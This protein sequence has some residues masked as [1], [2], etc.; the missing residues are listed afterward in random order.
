MDLPSGNAQF[1]AYTKAREPVAGPDGTTIQARSQVYVRYYDAIKILEINI[2]GRNGVT[3]GQEVR[4]V[5]IKFDPESVNL[6]DPFSAYLDPDDALLPILQAAFD[7]GA[8]V[9]VGLESVR[10]SKNGK[11]KGAIAAITPIHALRGANQD[12]SKGGMDASRDNIRNIISLVDGRPSKKIVSDPTEW[13]ELIHNKSGDLAPEGFRTLLSGDDWAKAGVIVPDGA[14]RAAQA[15]PQ[16]NTAI[17]TAIE[18]L[19]TDLGTQIE[20]LLSKLA[21]DV[22]PSDTGSDIA[23]R[24]SKGGFSEGKPWES[25]TSNGSLNLGSYQLSKQRAIFQEAHGIVTALSV[26]ADGAAF[27]DDDESWELARYIMLITDQV[28][29]RTYGHDT[30]IDRTAPSHSEAGKWVTWTIAQAALE[31]EAYPLTDPESRNGWASAIMESATTHFSAAA[32]LVGEYL[33]A[34]GARTQRPSTQAPAAPAENP[35]QSRPVLLA[36]AAGVQAASKNADGLKNFGNSVNERGQADVPFAFR[37]V[38]GN[39]EVKVAAALGE[40]T[41]G[42]NIGSAIQIIHHL[43][44]LATAAPAPTAT[45]APAPAAESAPPAPAAR[46]ASVEYSAGAKTII[47]MLSTATTSEDVGAAYIAARDANVLDEAVGVRLVESGIEFG[48][49]GQFTPQPLSAILDK[50]R[51]SAK[52][53]AATPTV[54]PAAAPE[55]AHEEEPPEEDEEPEEE[56]PAYDPEPP[57]AL[58]AAPAD[59]TAVRAQQL[60]DQAAAASAAGD[61]ATLNSL[62][63]EAAANDLTGVAITYMGSTGKLALLLAKFQKDIAA[64]PAAVKA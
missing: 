2:G 56:T 16:D 1:I 23:R 42:W 9:S 63:S 58:S 30:P 46:P 3:A 8:T 51:Q 14:P 64:T 31:G 38:D 50:F 41:D 43:H 40:D 15:A 28:Q 47:A 60:A 36:L 24:V 55:A 62:V 39:A 59:N 34:R 4:T 27:A 6:T 37:I 33:V 7:A 52:K 54:A 13:A 22:N 45:V 19:R 12:G 48:A 32:T 17:L 49:P 10:K 44:S 35:A 25:R 53:A 5:A 57:M 18:K 20:S 29:M 21:L 26:D 61:A 11:S